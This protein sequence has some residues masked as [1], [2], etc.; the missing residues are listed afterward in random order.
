[1][2][3]QAPNSAFSVALS[4]IPPANSFAMLARLATS[5]PPPTW[6]VLAT[7]VIGLLSAAGAVWFAAKIFKVGLLMQG[8]PP[9]FATL[10]RWARMA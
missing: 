3:G 9:S 8:K 4:F 1:V 2:I 5:T 10:V 6:Q 7:I